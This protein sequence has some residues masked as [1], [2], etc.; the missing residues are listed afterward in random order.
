VG[1]RFF[2]LDQ[3]LGIGKGAWSEGVAR[4]AAWL[5]GLLPFAQAAAV[6]AE[7]GQV[8]ISDETVWRLSGACGEAF[9][10]QEAQEQERAKAVAHS[11]RGA[12]RSPRFGAA[13]D[14]TMIH[15]RGEGWKELKVGC[16]F[17]VEPRVVKDTPTGEESEVGHAVG[18]S[19]VGHLG[20]PQ[21]FGE[22]LWAEAC[23]RGWDRVAET[24]V[25]GD[26]AAWIW[27]LAAEHFYDSEQVVDW[28]HGMEHLA[29]AAAVAYGEGSAATQRWL[30]KQETV[31][32]QGDAAKIAQTLQ[33]MVTKK[34][35][36][37]GGDKAGEELCKEAAYFEHNKRRMNY[38]ELRAA[39]WVIGSGM[40][41]SGGKRFKARLA[42][43]GMH[44]SRA[45]AERLIPIRAAILSDRF[46]ACWDNS[47]N[48][49]KS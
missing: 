29:H 33:G 36:V 31:L 19:Y 9:Q 12:E 38:L 3:Q 34:G 7:V 44:W 4:R 30:K 10:V 41:E 25:I 28:Y 8:S 40:V 2:P 17:E 1:S 42:G 32:Y 14:G 43:A 18:S 20:G 48:S 24:E 23:R 21:V 22:R 39:G 46:D 6:F 5:G 16:V 13:L 47:H 37:E 27:N 11:K 49:P 35:A 15:V 45:G 26:G